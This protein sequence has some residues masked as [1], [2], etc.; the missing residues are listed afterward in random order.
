MTGIWHF[1]YMVF[2]SSSSFCTRV[3]SSPF[4]YY[5]WFCSRVVHH[6]SSQIVARHDANGFHQLPPAHSNVNFAVFRLNNVTH[7]ARS[8]RIDMLVSI[9]KGSISRAGV[10]HASWAKRILEL[11]KQWREINIFGIYIT[12]TSLKLSLRRWIWNDGLRKDWMFWDDR[13]YR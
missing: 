13:Q 5:L 1:H 12:V 9:C 8:D 10:G 4:R 11:E 6:L 3:S 7:S 2:N